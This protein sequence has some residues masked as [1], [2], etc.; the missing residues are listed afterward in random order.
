[1]RPKLFCAQLGFASITRTARSRHGWRRNSI[2]KCMLSSLF[3]RLKD[4]QKG[5]LEFC[6]P[7]KTTLQQGGATCQRIVQQNV[8]W[9]SFSVCS[10][11]Q[12]VLHLR[13]RGI[14]VAVVGQKGETCGWPNELRTWIT[15]AS[16]SRH[17]DV[18]LHDDHDW[19]RRQHRSGWLIVR[20]LTLLM[21]PI[22]LIYH[23]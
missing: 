10:V 21:R 9:G 23:R 16:Q 22:G 8:T 18:N 4:P 13:Y 11:T 17:N 2:I 5:S 20:A 7:Y 15:C 12:L 6:F 19:W 14:P 1:M 3:L